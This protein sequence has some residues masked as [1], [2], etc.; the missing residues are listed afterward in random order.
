MSET[1]LTLHIE[2]K[3]P[4]ELVDL[5]E[6]FL[7]VADEYKR[8]SIK[9]PDPRNQND[10]K[11]Y[12]K[13]IKT[14]TITASLIDYAPL[15]LP[16][17]ENVITLVEFSKFLKFSYNFLTG[18]SNEKPELEKQDYVNLSKIINPIAKDNGS[19]INIGTFVNGNVYLDFTIP[20]LDANAAQN[21][22]SRE[23]SNLKE[24]ITNIH[25]KVVL[26]WY[27]ARNVPSATVGD[28][29]IIE[30]IS[31]KPVKIAFA[32]DELKM[33]LIH[34]EANP[35]LSAF[36]VDVSVETINDDPVLYKVIEIYDKFEKPN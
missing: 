15:L 26:Y 18:K 14:G 12:V 33:K 35:F 20:S 13:E 23:L 7:S 28:K 11:L 22:I 25:T 3:K 24:P 4:V 30:S 27:Q 6:S 34:E 2:N 9:L 21:N 31:K 36:V 1:I 10:I 5:T 19:Q 16:F 32:K 8:F 29:A 17:A